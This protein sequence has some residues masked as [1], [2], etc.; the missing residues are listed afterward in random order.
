MSPQLALI[1]IQKKYENGFTA[2]QAFDLEVQ[3]NEFIALLGPS[4]CGKSTLLRM[5][6]GLEEISAGSLQINGKSMNEIAPQHR[7]IA[8]V[9]QSYAL[10][11]HLNAYDNIAFALRLKGI[12]EDQIKQRIEDLAQRLEI[13]ALLYRKPKE[14]S[15]GQRQ[16]IAI[17]RALAKQASILL[18]DEP[19]SNLDTQ[20][21]S[22]MRIEIAKIHREFNAT[23]LYV[24][25]DQVEAMTLATRIV[26]LKNG[27]IQ[28]IGTPLNLYQKP[29]NQFVA[30]FIGQ[31]S[32]NLWH[33]KIDQDF[34]LKLADIDIAIPQEL[35]SSLQSYSSLVL[36]IRANDLQIITDLQTHPHLAKIQDV[37]VEL[38]EPLGNENLVY[39]HK[40]GL[41]IIIRQDPKEVQVQINQKVHIA[42]DFKNT[43]LFEDND[44]GLRIC[45]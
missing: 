16:R 5:I 6:A 33:F 4:G 29:Q 25:H 22:Q 3:K 44:M 13:S 40:N 45:D 1:Q 32:M 9:F 41:K 18:F 23:T 12:A 11:P 31:P 10:Y 35:R 8:M 19:L 38:I 28:Q 34:R 42:F 20:L 36:G 24:T 17:A 21:R 30:A 15:G 39:A 43:H 2:I 14:M 37:E 26:L 7:D 27:M